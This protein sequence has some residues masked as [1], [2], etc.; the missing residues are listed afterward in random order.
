MSQKD[1]APDSS[2]IPSA[3]VLVVFAPAHPELD[4]AGRARSLLP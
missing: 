1:D 3:E 4:M 2:D